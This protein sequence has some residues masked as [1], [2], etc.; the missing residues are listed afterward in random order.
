MASSRKKGKK[1]IWIP[2]LVLVAALAVGAVLLVVG[3]RG[4]SARYDDAEALLRDYDSAQT[5]AVTPAEDGGVTLRL[6]REDL[7]W[8]A[9]RYG[10]LEDVRRDLADAG[11]SAAGFRLSDGRLTVFARY[12]TW[13]ILPLHYQ[14]SIVLEW[15]GGL[16]F[17]TEKLSFGNHMTIPRSRWPEVFSR[18]YAIPGEKISPLVRGA[19]LE[20]DA[21]VLV[22]E[23]LTASMRGEAQPDA[24]LLHT[25]ALFGVRSEGDGLLE[26]FVRSRAP[27]AIS[28]EEI[29]ALLSA[30]ARSDALERLLC[31]CRSGEPGAL[32]AEA[33]MLTEDMLCRPLRHAVSERRAALEARLAAEQAKYEKLLLAVRESYKSGGLAIAETGFVSLTTGQAFDPAALTTLSASATDCRIV[34]LWSS[35]GGG[36]YCTRDM[37]AA[38]EVTRADK[39]AM[40]GLLDPATRY[41][42]GVTLSSEGGVPLLICRRA[43][44]TF[45]LR[46][47]D[48][49]QF[50]S[51]LVERS[52]PVLDMAALPAPGEQIE[53]PAGE[54]W[55]GA[56]ILTAPSE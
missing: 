16:R 19:Y 37:P 40:D 3:G 27:E 48:E 6:T 46:E 10:L 55:S 5:P 7:Y 9:R 50:V 20:G 1:W 28:A 24:E 43:D 8:Y 2:V 42:L 45:V 12:T 23:G 41:D 29:R 56:V 49:A 39:T 38:G 30:D 47:L 36:E 22:H 33:D 21:L 54:G 4:L 52:N 51:L 44:D 11:I 18:T 25:M 13:G 35:R 34:F 17:R 53:R 31:L 32:W 14:A 15:D 26:D